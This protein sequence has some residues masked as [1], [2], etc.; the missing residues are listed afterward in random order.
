[1]ELKTFKNNGF[2]TLSTAPQHAEEIAAR[3]ITAKRLFMP[4]TPAREYTNKALV[5]A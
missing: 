1:M 3:V 5:Y 2:S 4:E